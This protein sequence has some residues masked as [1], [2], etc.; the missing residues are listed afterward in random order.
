MRPSEL[1]YGTVCTCSFCSLKS[2]ASRLSMR[3][4]ADVRHGYG[5]CSFGMDFAMLPHEQQ[6]DIEAKLPVAAAA[7]SSKPA[8]AHFCCDSA[9]QA[10]TDAPWCEAECEASCA[11]SHMGSCSSHN[12]LL[13]HRTVITSCHLA[14]TQVRATSCLHQVQGSAWTC[15]TVLSPQ[16][17]AFSSLLLEPSKLRAHCQ[18]QLHTV[19]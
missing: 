7:A 14:A 3:Q 4:C 8:T 17:A 2:T 13:F 6:C 19:L 1:R 16:A 12:L 15:P 11:I 18:D 9:L 5:Q 10:C